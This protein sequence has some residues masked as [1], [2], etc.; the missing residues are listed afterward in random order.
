M[1]VLEQ[2]EYVGCIL[3]EQQADGIVASVSAYNQNQFND[4]WHYHVNAH[5]SFVLK[6][7]RSEQ[8]KERY[9]CLRGTATFYVPGEVHRMIRMRNSTHINLE[10]EQSFLQKY[11]ITEQ[12][13]EN[14]FRKTPDTVLMMLNIYRELTAAD[15]YTDASISLLLMKFLDQAEGWR[16]THN[17]PVW[18]TIVREYLHD[19][20]TGKISLTELAEVTDVHPVTISHYFPKYFSSTLGSYM[21][22]LKVEKALAM[23]NTADASLTSIAYACGFFDQSHFTRTFKQ[24]TGFL[25]AQ[26]QK[27]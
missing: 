19:N 18:V 21:R 17:I 11:H 25:P 2:G 9:E 16:F 24:L 13:M 8:K 27:L 4:N 26:Y 3:K 23:L 7:G 5:I 1:Q 20:W 10:L 12:E 22:K 15:D 6:G 14:V